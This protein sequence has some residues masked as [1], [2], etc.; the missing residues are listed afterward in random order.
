M[1]AWHCACGRDAAAQIYRERW[2]SYYN[3]MVRRRMM[4]P[5][6]IKVQDSNVCAVCV[7]WFRPPEARAEA[8]AQPIVTD[9]DDDAQHLGSCRLRVAQF[10]PRTPRAHRRLLRSVLGVR[11][12]DQ[13]GGDTDHHILVRRQLRVEIDVFSLWRSRAIKLGAVRLEQPAH[14][15]SLSLRARFPRPL[16]GRNERGQVF[17]IPDLYPGYTTRGQQ[18]GRAI[19]DSSFSSALLI[20]QFYASTVAPQVAAP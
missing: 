16:L 11:R 14:S 7:E 3:G 10:I 12:T 1:C 15:L 2:S 4:R 8:P 5:A 18:K 6:R 17:A 9:I 20:W 13:R 19:A